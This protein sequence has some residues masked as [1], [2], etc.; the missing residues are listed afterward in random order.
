M[1]LSDREREIL[2]FEGS[3][4][5]HSGPKG[6]VIRSRLRM[7]PGV[8][9]RRLAALV[10]NEEARAHAPLVVLRL[11]KR[12]ERRQKELFSGLSRRNDPRR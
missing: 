3:W 9:Y 1:A 2:D 7:A 6:A 12:R 11:R 10:D 4:W 8:Y 5:T